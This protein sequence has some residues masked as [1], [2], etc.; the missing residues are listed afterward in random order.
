VRVSSYIF[1]G[2]QT[3]GFYFIGFCLS[4]RAAYCL[5]DWVSLLDAEGLWMTSGAAK[6]AELDGSRF[7]KC[8]SWLA[9]DAFCRGEL[10]FKNPA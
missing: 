10:L 7:L 1:V 9:H 6:R 8:F 3:S 5:A 4:L 2:Q